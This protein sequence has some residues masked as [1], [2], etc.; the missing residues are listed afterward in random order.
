MVLQAGYFVAWTFICMISFIAQ[1]VK[2]E[3]VVEC[4]IQIQL[5]DDP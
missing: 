2:Q 1:P 5:I 3:S 4:V